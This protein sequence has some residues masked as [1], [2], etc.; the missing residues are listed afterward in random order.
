[1]TIH[2]IF[3]GIPV[4]VDFEHRKIRLLGEDWK[5]IDLCQVCDFE[6]QNP[7]Q[8]NP[9][10]SAH[11]GMGFHVKNWQAAKACY[12]RKANSDKRVRD[13]AGHALRG[14]SK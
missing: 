2:T 13:A 12:E 3:D 6:F 4:A 14:A 9:D 8:H 11:F 10:G 7:V 1:M 5:P